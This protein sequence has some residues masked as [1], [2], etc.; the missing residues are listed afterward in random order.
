MCFFPH[1]DLNGCDPHRFLSNES[2]WLELKR[3]GREAD[4]SNLSNS[5]VAYCVCVCVYV[6]GWVA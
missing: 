1:D 3:P 6:W 5:E 4:L 2:V